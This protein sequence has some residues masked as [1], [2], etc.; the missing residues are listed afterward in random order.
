MT[1]GGGSGRDR[2]RR[3][4]SSLPRLARPQPPPPLGN[5]CDVTFMAF[6]AVDFKSLH[7]GCLIALSSSSLPLS[8]LVLCNIK[9]KLL[10]SLPS[11]ENS[12]AE[13]AAEHKYPTS[14]SCPLA[15][16]STPFFP[17]NPRIGSVPRQ[18]FLSQRGFFPEE[19]EACFQ[20]GALVKTAQPG[21]AW[22]C[23]RDAPRSRLQVP[24][25][26]KRCGCSQTR[27]PRL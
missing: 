27:V 16:T 14:A 4:G 18:L 3:Q 10:A 2:C 8:P 26:E 22:G 13:P 21:A 7:K 19:E 1:W 11:R 5:E 17:R 24:R 23:G 25:S 20:R 6:S 9:N 15:P 12:A